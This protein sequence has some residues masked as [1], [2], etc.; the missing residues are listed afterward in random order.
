MEGCCDDVVERD[1]N[2]TRCFLSLSEKRQPP[3]R[4]LLG[5]KQTLVKACV[6][7]RDALAFGLWLL[8]CVVPCTR[9][10]LFLARVGPPLLVKD[11][12]VE[13]D[14]SSNYLGFQDVDW[15]AQSQSVVRTSV[16]RC[17]EDGVNNALLEHSALPALE[18]LW[19]IVTSRVKG[20]T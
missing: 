2:G 11:M 3:T 19:S 8:S 20:R 5:T 9:F 16:I 10:S 14:N 7:P 18:Q 13:V 12:D 15:L 4:D 6:S 1:G 17:P